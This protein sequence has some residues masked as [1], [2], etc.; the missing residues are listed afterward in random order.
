MGHF[1]AVCRQTKWITCFTRWFSGKHGW[2]HLLGWGR[3]SR[4]VGSWHG[5]FDA[6]YTRV[7]ERWSYGFL[8][9]CTT[10]CKTGLHC[11]KTKTLPAPCRD[12]LWHIRKRDHPAVLGFQHK[13]LDSLWPGKK[14][15]QETQAVPGFFSCKCF[16]VVS[17]PAS[18]I[19]FHLEVK[20]HWKTAGSS[21]LFLKRLWWEEQLSLS[22]TV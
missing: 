10:Q 19:P 8:G 16:A 13:T 1:Q 15:L 7:G 12:Q 22:E 20:I 14:A 9:W 11:E 17:G 4:A 21:S 5:A 2:T 18:D 6:L 3:A